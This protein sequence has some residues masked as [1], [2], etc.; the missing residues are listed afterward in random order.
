MQKQVFTRDYK[1]PPPFKDRVLAYIKTLLNNPRIKNA[2]KNPKNITIV[3]LLLTLIILILAM[4]TIGAR[5]SDKIQTTQNGPAQS[6]PQSKTATPLGQVET[7]L[8]DFYRR[9]EDK[10]TSL[11]DLKKPIVELDLGFPK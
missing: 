10:S 3:S 7:E 9:L 6:L 2:F 8:N 5:R 4:L 11:N 1:A